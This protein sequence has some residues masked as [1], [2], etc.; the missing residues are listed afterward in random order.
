MLS[1]EEVQKI[2]SLARLKL[3][4]KE[5][6]EMGKD[7]SSILDYFKLIEKA[8]VSDVLPDFYSGSKNVMRDDRKEEVKEARKIIEQAPMKEGKFVKVR[9]ILK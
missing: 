1:K 7:L 2:A 9:E 5:I 3:T 8:D 6:E 4:E